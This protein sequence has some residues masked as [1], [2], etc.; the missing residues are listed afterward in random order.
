MGKIT[1][2]KCGNNR[3]FVAVAASVFNIYIDG[4]GKTRSKE[5]LTEANT[6]VDRVECQVCHAENEDVG[7]DLKR[8]EVFLF[9]EK[10]AE[11]VRAHYMLKMLSGERYKSKMEKTADGLDKILYRKMLLDVS[12]HKDILEDVL[13]MLGKEPPEKVDR[14]TAQK[15]GTEDK[16][17]EMS[18]DIL[19][20]LSNDAPDGRLRGL[21]LNLIG[22]EKNHQ[23]LRKEWL[24]QL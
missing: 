9:R 8:G 22:D 23:E 11:K 21:F 10:L 7:Y 17:E 15:L 12:R 14:E 20:Q 1:C 4:D 6:S 3:E 16:V 2:P 19:R 13:R 24:L 5:P 18:K